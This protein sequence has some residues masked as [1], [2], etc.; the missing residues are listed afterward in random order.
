MSVTRYIA[1]Q[2]NRPDRHRATTSGDFPL[3]AGGGGAA[4]Q[5][6]MQPSFTNRLY[7]LIGDPTITMDRHPYPIPPDA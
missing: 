2:A 4:P 3:L 1:D 5:A 6:I 7:W